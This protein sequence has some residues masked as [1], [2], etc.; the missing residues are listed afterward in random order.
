MAYSLLL[1][2]ILSIPTVLSYS[3]FLSNMYSC[4]DTYAVFGIM[5]T[6]RSAILDRDWLEEHFPD[7]G[8]FASDVVRNTMGNAVYGITVYFSADGQALATDNV[9]EEVARLHAVLS[10]HYESNGQSPPRM[11]YYLVISGDYE[12]DHTSYIP[13]DGI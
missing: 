4:Y 3:P 2:V 9:K 8:I 13:Y 7:I 6:D 12:E 10:K 5:E 1:L 11:A